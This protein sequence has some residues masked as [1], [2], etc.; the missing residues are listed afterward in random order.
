MMLSFLLYNYLTLY[1]E[2][3]SSWPSNKFIY[4]IFND[5]ISK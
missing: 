1:N 3:P 2:D 4:Y 5:L